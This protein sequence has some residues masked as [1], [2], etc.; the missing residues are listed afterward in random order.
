M[1]RFSHHGLARRPL[2]GV[3]LVLATC[4]LASMAP[5]AGTPVAPQV[6]APVT[7]R[8][9][10][11]ANTPPGDPVHI[12]GDFQGWS[13]S[14]PAYRLTDEGGRVFAI[15]L[16]LTVGTTIQFKFA[17]GDWSK[18]EKGPS[19]EEIANRVHAVTGATT[20]NLTVANWADLPA[21]SSIVGDV[22]THTV[23]GFLNG[24]R[25]WVYLP[26]GYHADTAR[27]YPVLYMLDGQNVFDRFTSFAG[28]WDVDETCEALIAAGLM[29]PI[30]V[31]AV[32]NGGAS[33]VNE[34]TPW[35]DAGYQTGGGADAHL[36]AFIDVLMPWVNAGW[37]TRT[38]P[39]NTGLAG[40]SLGGLLPLYAAYARPDVFGLIGALSPSI[41]WSGSAL[42][43]Y[44]SGQPRPASKVYMDMGTI[45][46]GHTVDGN[47]NGVDDYIDD[48]RAMRDLMV[49]QGYTLDADLLV[50]E[51][52]GG[53]HNEWHWAQRFPMAL[54]F[55][56]PMPA[57]AAPPGAAPALLVLR[58]NAPNPFNPRTT[59]GFYLPDGGP[60]R[61]SVFD[62]A[63]RLVRT[64]VAGSMPRGSHEAVWD[65]RDSS[66]RTVASG[67]YLARL[68]FGGMVETVRM[69]LVR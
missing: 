21:G 63:G 26:P 69:G 15:T 11:P 51:A 66:G 29:A 50:L 44:A 7:I 46:A 60:V 10:V 49:G 65:G 35:V 27:R 52:E 59:I 54:Q 67:S 55:L 20:L 6:T 48:L 64:L 41:W 43:D 36:Q 3:L 34:Y 17:R 56:F 32:D 4:L 24:R 62:V 31:V 8:V 61:L 22:T 9:S 57:S 25:V 58:P 19:G 12:A 40:S 5:A 68:E 39:Q 33:R 1:P 42:L 53:V 18:V 14:D 2:A 23:P 16:N 13:P 30:I 37:R 38:G 47:A 45:E 28:E